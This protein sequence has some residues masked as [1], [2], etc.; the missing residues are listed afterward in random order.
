M[1]D[2]TC[3]LAF[4]VTLKDEKGVQKVLYP[5]SPQTSLKAIFK[6]NSLVEWLDGAT[7]NALKPRCRRHIYINPTHVT[8]AEDLKFF[9]GGAYIL[10]DGS[11]SKVIPPTAAKRTRAD[12]SEPEPEPDQPYDKKAAK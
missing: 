11:R 3:R 8:V 9:L 4:R 10:D 1:D 7:I 5:T 6:A 12:K 2:P